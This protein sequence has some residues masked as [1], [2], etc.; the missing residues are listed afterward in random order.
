[1]NTSNFSYS[2]EAFLL[3]SLHEV[4]KVWASGNGKADF[5]LKIKDGTA[6]LQL[7]FKLGRP[8]DDH[9]VPPHHYNLQQPQHGLHHEQLLPRRPRRRHKGPARREKDRARAEQHQACLKSK[10]AESAEILLLFKGRILPLKNYEEMKSTV[11][12][13]H[14]SSPTTPARGGSTDPAWIPNRAAASAPHQTPITQAKKTSLSPKYID[15]N[16]VRKKLFPLQTPHDPPA[17]EDPQS[18]PETSKEFQRRE[19]NLWARIFSNGS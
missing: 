6:D 4:V 18:V 16:L 7:A 2:E 3:N 19:D 14:A 12:V 11:S 5:S 8:C 10:S 15:Y 9:V 13:N 17:H 1:M